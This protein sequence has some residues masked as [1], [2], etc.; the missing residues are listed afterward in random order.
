MRRILSRL[1]RTFVVTA[2]VILLGVAAGSAYGYWRT[3]GSGSG[4]ASTGTAQAVTIEA[5]NGSPATKLIPG[6]TADLVLT[7]DNPNSYAVTIVGIA[8]NTGG[9][10]SIVG[11]AGCTAGNSAVSVPTQSGLSVAVAPGSGQTVHIAKGAAM[12]TASNSGCQGASFQIPVNVTVQ[13]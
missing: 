6:N 13:R 1:P 12:G 10:V 2:A 3:S 9:S 4:T 7:L 8:Q 11:G 5:A